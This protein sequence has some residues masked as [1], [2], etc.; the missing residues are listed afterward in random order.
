MI[1]D[2]GKGQI[3]HLRTNFSASQTSAQIRKEGG[4]SNYFYKVSVILTKAQQQ[5]KD[6]PIFLRCV[7]VILLNKICENEVQK[8]HSL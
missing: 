8:D 6:R 4:P 7:D 3:C 5:S 1:S 2:I